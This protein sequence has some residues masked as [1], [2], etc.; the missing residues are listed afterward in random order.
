MLDVPENNRVVK[1][2]KSSKM[3][4]FAGGG[5]KRFFPESTLIKMKESFDKKRS[6]N[7][8]VSV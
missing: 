1:R 5:R 4:Q 8:S 7:L 3:K 6:E 2:N